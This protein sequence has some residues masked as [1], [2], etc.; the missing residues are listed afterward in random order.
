M[1][2]VA[3]L[4]KPRDTVFLDT[5]RDDVL[6]LSDLVE[7]KIDADKFFGEN[8]KT[9]GMD[10]LLNAAF[11]RFQG[12]SDT[13][14]IKLTQAMGGG[15]THNM[16]ALALL[17][18]N[19]AWRTKLLGSEYDA[20]DEIK[21]VAFSGRESDV[22]YG[23]WGSIAAQLGKR[24]LFSE[25]YS[26]LRAPGE[27]AWINLLS[28]QNILILLDEL[29]PYLENAKAVTVGNSDLCKVTVTALSNL[30]TALGKKQLSNVCLVFSDLKATYESASAL[31]QSS[32]NELENEANR[33]AI[34]IEPVAL[35]SDEVYDILKMRLFESFPAHNSF[36]VND[37]AKGYSDA[38]GRAKKS[39]FTQCDD[40][41]FFAGI[42]DSYPFHPSIKELYARF[43]ENPNFQQTRGLIKLMRQIV[44]Q[45]YECGKAERKYLINVFDI[46]L[47][48]RNMLS[49]IKQ[50]KPS[51]EAAISHDIAQGGRAAAEI[52]DAQ[53]ET[54]KGEYAQDAG[55]LLLM[56]SLNDI[57]HGL[58]GLTDSET[59]SYLCEPGAD[60][61]RYK[62]ALEEL[63]SQCWYIKQDNRGRYYFQNLKNMIAEMNTLVES[64]SNEGAKKELRRFLGDNFKPVLKKCYS[65]LYILPA[66]DE[67][68]LARDK[69][70]LVI[71]EPYSGSGLHPDLL[72]LY[73][74]A[75]YK[76]RV[77]F[78]SG[79]R[80][81][82]EK[83]YGNSKRLM[84]ITQIFENMKAEHVPSTDQ[85]YK[86]A[87]NQVDKVTTAL[88]QTVRETFLTL[89]FPT[90]NGIASEDFRLEFKENKFNGEE[91]IIKVLKEAD[92]FEDFSSE[93]RMLDTMQKKCEQRIFT[94]K[95]MPWSQIMERAATEP[96][97][98][99]YHPQQME[100]L[101]KTCLKKDRWRE[102]AGYIVKGPFAKDPTDVSI[103]QMDYNERTGEFTL[104]TRAIHGNVIYYDIGAEPST[105][106]AQAPSP[107]VTKE[108][109]IWFL[110]VDT[111]ED[112]PHPTGPAK[113]FMC[114]V[115]LRHEQRLTPNGSVLE[116]KT[117]R[118]F[119]IRYTTDGSS[120]KESGGRY[121]G[122]IALPRGCKYVRTAVLYKGKSV[123]EKD[124]P[125][126]EQSGEAALKIDSAKPLE[127]TMRSQKRCKDT[128]STYS[129]FQKLGSMPG[130]FVR[131]F[132][133]TISDKSNTNNYMQLTTATVPYDPGSLQATVDLIRETAFG[134]KDVIIEFEYKTMAFPDGAQFK[135]WIELNKLDMN[136]LLKD[137]EVRQ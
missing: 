110:C 77:M 108:P 16:L 62:A 132:T 102:L 61:D 43:K 18:Q 49:Y 69:I 34:N 12:K 89:Y 6:N 28:G 59:L 51:L 97:W 65:E 90:R 122:E 76:N 27:S 120:P 1:Q 125:I 79:Q 70:S 115:P 118:D 99:W 9:K 48:D 31:L 29:P 15:K 101:K 78:L 38:L 100:E 117:H 32:F 3:E 30:F 84:A 20:V 124:I 66:L 35:N 47:N 5:T 44:R 56:S 86:E 57:T 13:G 104:K 25:L 131:H 109:A 114:R 92:K 81:V 87:E 19:P 52:I 2:A 54:A 127:Y 22:P 46:D 98:Q 116:L 82:M 129:E 112:N 14:V 123:E 40:K 58:Q 73:N 63:K 21:V 133:V 7:G 68:T 83:L 126:T 95:E 85:Q 42:K 23:I 119:E 26:P 64:Y 94:Q 36:A 113:E 107:F 45:F 88:L 105:A 71:F 24:E 74:N 128:E 111:S 33:I 53:N 17:A 106:S 4:C 80:N 55:K 67:I 136:D 134:G 72:A 103:E 41:A 137:G 93:D 50:I 60:M 8:F 130:A 39:G 121:D 75:S 135:N 10:I 11:G 91:Q 96:Q 37:I